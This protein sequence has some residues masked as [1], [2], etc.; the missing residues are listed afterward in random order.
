M[1]VLQ[2]SKEPVAPI[3]VFQEETVE[4]IQLSPQERVSV[5]EARPPRFDSDLAESSDEESS[6][7]AKRPRHWSRRHWGRRQGARD[8][9]LGL[10]TAGLGAGSAAMASMA[11]MVAWWLRWRRW[12]PGSVD[13]VE[14][15]RRMVVDWGLRHRGR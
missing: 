2:M 13:G 1:A 5:D 15:W 4:V 12:W 9:W 7:E 11:S 8:G 6:E 3:P 10:K 14:W